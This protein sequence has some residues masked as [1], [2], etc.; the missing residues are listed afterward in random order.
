MKRL[1]IL[2]LLGGRG[3]K[4]MSAREITVSVLVPALVV[5]GVMVVLAFWL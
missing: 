5:I 3:E 1:T 2:G 4:P